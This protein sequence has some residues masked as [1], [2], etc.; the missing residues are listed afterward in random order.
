MRQRVAGRRPVLQFPVDVLSGQDLAGS[1][2][3]GVS[4]G[5]GY[6]A[7]PPELP[8]SKVQMAG[9]ILDTEPQFQANPDPASSLADAD[10]RREVAPAAEPQC[11]HT[12]AFLPRL[13]RAVA[14]GGKLSTCL[15]ESVDA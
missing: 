7:P 13:A 3:V 1:G 9:D 5:Q 14:F 11:P 2:G 6:A 4:S 10:A 8:L 12:A 15:T